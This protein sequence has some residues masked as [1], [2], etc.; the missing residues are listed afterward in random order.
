MHSALRVAVVTFLATALAMTA[1]SPGNAEQQ[2]S[3][4]V[5]TM[6][7]CSGTL[8]EARSIKQGS[9]TLGNLYVYWNGT[10]NCART[11]SSNVTWGT[12]KRMY[13]EIRSCP[14]SDKG[15]ELCHW[16]DADDDYG[17]FRY[18]AGPV[19]VN[20]VAKCIAA[21]GYIEWGGVKHY[22]QT[23]PWVG[24]CG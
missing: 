1:A 9:T 6:A 20:G 8:I 7:S 3:G 21:R 13:A 19:K 22:A 11:V 12:P 4:Q 14:R 5:G 24:H 16:L 23:N 15:S 10:Y 18:Y 2:S 17:T